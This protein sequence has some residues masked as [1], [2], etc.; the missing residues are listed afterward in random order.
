MRL[1]IC[2]WNLIV[3]DIF[4]IY[5]T[6]VPAIPRGHIFRSIGVPTSH[7]YSHYSGKKGLIRRAQA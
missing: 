6:P 4:Y 2:I 5:F 3:I 7:Q 1:A